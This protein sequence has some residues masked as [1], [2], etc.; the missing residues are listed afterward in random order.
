[1]DG[2]EA[3]W[4]IPTKVIQVIY[5]GLMGHRG[6]QGSEGEAVTFFRLMC[7]FGGAKLDRGLAGG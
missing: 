6:L 5:L 2:Y 4:I 1:M 3:D 7:N